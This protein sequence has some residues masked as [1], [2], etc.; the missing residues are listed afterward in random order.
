MSFH[1]Q[2]R[3]NSVAGSDDFPPDFPHRFRASVSARSEGG[4]KSN[5]LSRLGLPA[6]AIK[7]VEAS[8]FETEMAREFDSSRAM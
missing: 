4:L 1:A 6:F 5:P 7:K 2:N 3:T 8:N